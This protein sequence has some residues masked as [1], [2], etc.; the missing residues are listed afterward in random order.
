MKRWQSLL[1]GIIVSVVLLAYALNG[2]DLNKLSGVLVSGN[3]LY[4]IPV[5]VITLFSM[6][7]RSLRWRTLLKDRITINHSFNILNASYLFNTILPLRLGEV[8]RAFLVTRLKPPIPLFTALSSIVVERL[9]DLFAVVIFV[10][11]AVLIAPVDPGIQ[12]AAKVTAI[13]A[14]VGTVVLAVFAARPSLAHQLLNTVLR[15][16]PFLE[17]LH[18]RS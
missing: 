4:L 16:V 17:R 2:V 9:M 6:L 1:L 12:A 5:I 3:Y 8:V 14:V 11:I 18:L 10:V 7:F 13:V 15:L